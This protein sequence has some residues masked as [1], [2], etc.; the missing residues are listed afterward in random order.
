MFEG[1]VISINIADAAEAPMQSVNEAR[2]VPGRGLEGDRYFNGTG[3]FSKP[4]P[5]RELTLIEAEAVEAMKRELDVDYGLGD[6]RRNVVTRGAPLN[7]LVGKEFWIGE[8]KARG[9]RLCEPCKHL[10]KLSHEK[11]LPGLVH[12]GGLRAQIL[13]EG[14]IR[15]GEPITESY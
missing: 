6:S 1:K 7:H 4:S 12:R 8:V 14:T 11:V 3:T 2:A 13:S 9:L 10:Q 5:D 15:V